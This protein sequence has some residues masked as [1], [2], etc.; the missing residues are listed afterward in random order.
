LGDVPFSLLLLGTAGSVATGIF[1]ATVA[2][3]LRGSR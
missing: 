3:L 2:K 1:G